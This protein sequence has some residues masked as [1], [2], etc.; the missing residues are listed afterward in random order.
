M[1]RSAGGSP[2]SVNLRLVAVHDGKARFVGHHALLHDISRERDLEKQLRQLS[3]AV[4][5]TES[6]ASD[7]PEP[8]KPAGTV[9][10]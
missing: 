4:G 2:I 7:A 1:E 6:P 9:L 10:N 8:A 3:E 5:A